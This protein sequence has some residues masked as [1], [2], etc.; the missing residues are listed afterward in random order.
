ML[1]K[2]EIRD[3]FATKQDGGQYEKSSYDSYFEFFHN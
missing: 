1:E 2:G 3:E